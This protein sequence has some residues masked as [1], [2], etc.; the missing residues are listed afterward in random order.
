MNKSINHE[1][2]SP[3]LPDENSGAHPDGVPPTTAHVGIMEPTPREI[4]RLAYRFY[5]ED[6]KPEGCAEDHWLRA[7]AFLLHPENHSDLNLL[8]MPSEPEITPALDEKAKDLDQFLP[9][10]PHSG[11]DSM[12]QRIDIAIDSRARNKTEQDFKGALKNLQGIQR[13]K[14]DGADRMTIFF[15]ARRTN[16]AA[17]HEALSARDVDE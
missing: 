4:A 7:E 5:V 15:D 12:H 17:I 14:A 10:D 9:S 6:G 8:T 2:L 3:P 11:E 1:K 16:P 13:V